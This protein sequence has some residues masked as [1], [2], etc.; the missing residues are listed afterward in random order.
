MLRKLV[1][2]IMVVLGVA[3]C[4]CPVKS[5][6]GSCKKAEGCSYKQQ[7]PKS[8]GKCCKQTSHDVRNI[9]TTEM[10][11]IVDAKSALIF[12]AR[13][14]KYDDGRRIPGAKAL[15]DKAS[16]T[17]LA[18]AI[19]SKNSP[20]VTYCS[21]TQCPA[22]AKLAAHLKAN[23]YTNIIEYPE[24]IDGWVKSGNRYNNVK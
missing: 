22:S 1:V 21:N 7:C 20:V 9:S 12:D 2:L 17:E 11:Q 24:G 10:K 5:R 16:P 6:C 14:A 4:R 3:A 23:G 18:S 8:S 19:P 13:S 15:S